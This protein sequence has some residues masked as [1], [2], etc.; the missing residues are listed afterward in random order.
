MGTLAV[1]LACGV[2]SEAG[3]ATPQLGL[4]LLGIILAGTLTLRVQRLVWQ[5]VSIRARHSLLR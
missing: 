5:R 2:W 4:N 1:C 3:S